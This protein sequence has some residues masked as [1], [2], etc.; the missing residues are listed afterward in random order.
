MLHDTIIDAEQIGNV[1]D[2]VLKDLA[3][4]FTRHGFT[5]ANLLS[6][7]GKEVL[8]HICISFREEDYLRRQV[9]AGNK[10]LGTLA[11]LFLLRHPVDAAEARGLLG[12]AVVASLTENGILAGMEG[13]KVRCRGY[14]TPLADRWFLN[15]GDA[16]DDHPEHV[17]KLVLE[18]P[19]LIKTAREAAAAVLA[20]PTG[21]VLDFCSGSGVI[22]QGVQPKGWR[23]RGLDINPRAI[24]YARFNAR[25]NGAPDTEYILQDVREGVPPGQFDV[26]LA[27]PPYNAFIAPEGTESATDL[28][29]HSGRFGEEVYDAILDN[30][31]GVLAPGGFFLC[32]G[33]TLLKGDRLWHPLADQ[34]SRNGTVVL[35]H[36][37]IAPVQS[38]EGMRLQWNCTPDFEKL[39]P[40]SIPAALRETDAFDNVTWAIMI[41]QKGGKPGYHTVYNLPTDGVLI[42][43]QALR[44]L[45]QLFGLA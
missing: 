30:L 36:K 11:D 43:P 42:S 37:P 15:D 22:G 39:A 31:D 5:S 2:A 19:Y 33:I 21:A 26:A 18:Q 29:L 27:N 3:A 32:C 41:Y 10:V 1:P 12:D 20:K 38:W 44:D 28:T 7:F 24:R 14:I 13:G 23:V 45:R 6:I 25:L 16:H 40:G 4:A 34:L 35:L 9:L 8:R 17:I